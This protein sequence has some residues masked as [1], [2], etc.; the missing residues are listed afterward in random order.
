MSEKK[1]VTDRP[2]FPSEEE[3]QSDNIFT[4]LKYQL[5]LDKK[6]KKNT[7]VPSIKKYGSPLQ[8]SESEENK[9]SSIKAIESDAILK[10]L[11][12]KATALK[13]SFSESKNN[14]EKGF[15]IIKLN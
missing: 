5:N 4:V 15:F 9:L 8:Q 3:P 11:K 6:S 12:N 7:Y 13:N 10:I 1:I 2:I 14:N